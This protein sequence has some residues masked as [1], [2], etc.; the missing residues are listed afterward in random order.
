MTLKTCF[1]CDWQG[2]TRET[3]C[4][5]CGKQPLYVV[6]AS[7]LKGEEAPAG[8]HPGERS[9]EAPSAATM[10]PSGTAS[11]LSTPS[12]SPGD[13]REPNGRSA[14]STVAFVLAA[15]V[16]I[17][18]VGSWLN[19]DGERSAPAVS[20]GASPRSTQTGDSF[21]TLSPP[22]SP[23]TA[24]IDSARLVGIGRQS[25][26]VK[27]ISFSFSVPSGGW[28]RFGDLYISKSTV[29]VQEADAIIFWTDVGRS[30]YAVACGQWW[31]SPVGSVADWAAQASRK[32]GT[33]LVKGPL[34]V[35]I[36][37]YAAQHVVF[38]IRKDVAC[39]P[40]FFHTWKAVHEGPFWSGTRVGDTI[41]IW[42]VKVGEKVLF[43]EGDTHQ[44]AGADL[45]QEV[46][47][48]VAS[49]TFD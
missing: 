31:G 12:P 10:V 30:K 9:L 48:I 34:D 40:G 28:A 49:M 3:R 8:N 16:L 29:S 13:A 23:R 2:E 42:L 15:L 20:T 1:R 26:T 24:T 11:P 45:R 25:L 6:G 46:E 39:N 27:G 47:R 41:R 33:E 32:R 44:Y 17:V 21:S 43:I 5:N 19:R 38:I 14:R 37:G 4:P 7:P 18:V 35:T 22:P 36:G